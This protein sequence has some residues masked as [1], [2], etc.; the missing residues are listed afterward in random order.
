MGVI[1]TQIRIISDIHNE[2]G[3]LNL[4]EIPGESNQVLVLAGD[5][6]LADKPYTYTHF[7]EEMSDRFQDVIYIM[8]NHEFY[9]TSILRGVDKIKKNL[10]QHSDMPNVHVLDN[11]TLRIGNVSFVC[12]TLWTSYNNM[13]T[14]CMYQAELYMNDH[15]KIRTGTPSTPYLRKFMPHDAATLHITARNFLFPNIKKEKEDGQKVVMVTHQAPTVLSIA[16]CYKTGDMAILNGAYASSLEED[17]FK[18]EPDLIIHGHTHH[19]FDYELVDE[20]YGGENPHVMR[21]IC[22]PRGYEGVEENPDF[23][24][25]LVVDL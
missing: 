12:S 13:D 23:N 4:L 3:Q 24:P 15:K 11:E 5:I 1:M 17:L 16:D 21:I 6:G 18:S 14:F 20:V 8:G 7:L 25:T 2:F 19:S 10:R 9:G 22:N